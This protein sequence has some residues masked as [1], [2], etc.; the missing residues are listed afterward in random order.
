MPGYLRSIRIDR[1]NDDD[2]THAG[3]IAAFQNKFPTRSNNLLNLRDLEQ[4]LENLKRL[5]TAEADLQIVPVEGEPNQSDVVVQ[6]RQRLLPYRVSVGVDNSGSKATGKYQ[7]NITFS[8]D[9]P[10]GL[11]DMF[12]VNYV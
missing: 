12:Y 8:A 9:N 4:G 2:Q 10:L 11:S 5:P 1:S 3:R 6:W 7:G